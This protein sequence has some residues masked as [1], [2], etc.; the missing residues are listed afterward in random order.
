MADVHHDFR[1]TISW[2]ST[3]RICFFFVNIFQLFCKSKIYKFNV[4]L[5]IQ[6][7]IFRLQITIDYARF[8][9]AFDGLYYFCNVETS[10]FLAHKYLFSNPFYKFSAWKILKSKIKFIIILKCAFESADKVVIFQR[11][12]NIL[13][14]NDM[15]DLFRS[16]NSFLLYTFKRIEFLFLSEFYEFD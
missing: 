15:L 3:I 7:N 8:V 13:F 2:R 11:L 10:V 14:I 6:Q 4:P 16:I 5:S 1:C 12:K 9:Q